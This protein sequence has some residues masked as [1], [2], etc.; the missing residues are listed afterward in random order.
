MIALSKYGPPFEVP[1]TD[2]IAYKYIYFLYSTDDSSM[3]DNQEISDRVNDLKTIIKSR[4]L[5]PNDL[6]IYY[7]R[8]ILKAYKNDAKR[9]A[10]AIFK[11][12][13]YLFQINAN[14]LINHMIFSDF[15]V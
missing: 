1:V 11:G 12:M 8:A 7:L 10:D 4:G 2:P 14:Y 5:D 13:Y 9:A 15:R 6:L 3:E